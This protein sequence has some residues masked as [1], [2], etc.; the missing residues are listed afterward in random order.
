MPKE[1]LISVDRDRGNDLGN[2]LYYALALNEEDGKPNDWTI[3]QF[4]PEFT[5]A[6]DAYLT[7]FRAY[8]NHLD[9]EC[10]DETYADPD[11]GDRTFGGQVFASLSGAGIGFWDAR[12]REWGAAMN[13]ALHAYAGTRAPFEQMDLAKFHGRIHLAYRTAAFRTEYLTKMFATTWKH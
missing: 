2:F 4:H 5:A 10:P 1:N 9:E 12:D 11:A 7:G 6:A 8:L 3:H 13:D